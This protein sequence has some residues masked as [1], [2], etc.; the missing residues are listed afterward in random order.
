ML[1]NLMFH[2]E[3]ILPHPAGREASRG[4]AES[5]GGAVQWYSCY[6]VTVITTS[7]S[8]I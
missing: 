3:K 4:E 7:L 1:L 6:L 8:L 2:Y 5:R